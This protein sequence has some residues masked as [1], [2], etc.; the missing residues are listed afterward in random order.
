MLRNNIGRECGA[1]D[2]ARSGRVPDPGLRDGGGV[3]SHPRGQLIRPEDAGYD[4][5]GHVWNGS[6]DK[7]PG[8]IVRCVAQPTWLRP[9]A[10]RARTACS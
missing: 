10:S 8:L 3:R 9:S 5:A 2:P 6:I 7:R 4:E 1:R